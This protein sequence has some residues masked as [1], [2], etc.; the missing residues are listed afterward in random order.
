LFYLI[1]S[2]EDK[3]QPTHL[4]GCVWLVFFLVHLLQNEPI[5]AW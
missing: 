4:V 5:V 2:S 1:L 3:T